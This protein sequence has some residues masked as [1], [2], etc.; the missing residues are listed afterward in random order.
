MM[1]RWTRF[2][3]GLALIGLVGAFAAPVLAEDDWR[4]T[5]QATIYWDAVTTLENGDPITA[6]NGVLYAVY[7]RNTTGGEPIKVGSTQETSFVLT[8]EEEGKWRV[9]ISAVRV[10]PTADLIE[11]ATSW[12]DDPV[13]VAEGATFGVTHYIPL[14]AVRGLR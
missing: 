14:A 8:F 11:S 10:T 7:I 3:I 6:D 5:D 2:F 12:S 1:N 13:A 9:G 4:V